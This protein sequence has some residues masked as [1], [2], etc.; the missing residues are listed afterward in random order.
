MGTRSL[1]V[2]KR[3]RRRSAYVPPMALHVTYE[4]VSCLWWERRGSKW[5]VRHQAVASLPAGTFEVRPAQLEIQNP[6]ALA[7][8]L[9]R[10]LPEAEYPRRVGLVVPDASTM[11]FAFR[12]EGWPRRWQEQQ[13]LIRWQLRR[14]TTL[15]LDTYRVLWQVLDKRARV[16]TVAALAAWAPFLD[17]LEDLLNQQGIVPGLVIPENIAIDNLTWYYVGPR[18][19]WGNRRWM[20]IHWDGERLTTTYFQGRRLA[21]KRTHTLTPEADE[22]PGGRPAALERELRRIGAYIQDFHRDDAPET[23]FLSGSHTESLVDRLRTVFPFDLEV[24]NVWAADDTL[25]ALEPPW[26]W[27][28]LLGVLL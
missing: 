26:A 1:S 15:A 18:P 19:D 28:P 2:W 25:P 6:E 10:V 3:L 22:G 21:W 16:G 14:Q 9:G 13:Q 20:V 12:I 7:E 27:Q 8:A 4:R 17:R 24:L 5:H 23:V 11:F